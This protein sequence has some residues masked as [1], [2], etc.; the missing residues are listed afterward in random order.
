MN[1]IIVGCGRIGSELAFRVF[2]DGHQV[3]VIDRTTVS[4]ERLGTNFNGRMVCGD[5]LNQDVLER[6]GIDQVDGVAAVTSDDATNFVVARIAKEIFKVSNVVVRAYDPRRMEVFEAL[7]I[8]SIASSSWGAQRLYQLL[9]HPGRLP[10][11]TLGHGEV[12]LIE[13]QIGKED[14]GIKLADFTTEGYPVAVSR[15]GSA[16]LPD[17]NLELLAGDLVIISVAAVKLP[18]DQEVA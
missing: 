7:G 11:I 18:N 12:S 10:L 17:P 9:T 2:N 1:L 5:V 4:F 13:L 14:Q 6:A 15:K 16:L 3:T 8:R